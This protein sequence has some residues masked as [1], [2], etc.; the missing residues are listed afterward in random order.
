MDD[1]ADTEAIE[2][3]PLLVLRGTEL[4]YALVRLAEL[5]GPASVP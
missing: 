3:S 1:D 2:E 4:R 5:I